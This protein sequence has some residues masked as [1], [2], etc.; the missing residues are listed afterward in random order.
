MLKVKSLEEHKVY[1]ERL[2]RISFFYARKYLLPQGAESCIGDCIKKHTPLL[3]HALFHTEA[4][5]KWD[6]PDSLR[7][8]AKAEELVALSPEEFEEAM[9]AYIEEYAHQR[10]EM[11]Y[12]KGVG[13]AAPAS[14]HCGSLTYDPPS[15]K[16]PP[17][18]VAFHIANGV[19]PHSIFE[20]PDYLPKCLELLMAECRVRFGA[21]T[22]YTS[23]WLNDRP[24]WQAL[25]PKSWMEN[26]SPKVEP[27][28]PVWSVA[29]WGQIIDSRGCVVPEREQELR[30]TGKFR[31]QTRSSHCTFD[32][33]EAHLAA[34]CSVKL[35]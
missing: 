3:Y 30:A 25:F 12:P 7:I 13:V 29:S 15:P 11:N 9:W 27:F 8:L 18:W 21:D 22:L 2:A 26:M 10:A 17:T 24:R 1:I 34:L 14:W 20:S 32:E 4:R 23:T 33:L 19:G 5:D 35:S 31:Y 28:I 16:R 6:D